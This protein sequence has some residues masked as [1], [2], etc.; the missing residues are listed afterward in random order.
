MNSLLAG[1]VALLALI[2]V[3]IRSRRQRSLPVDSG[4]VSQTWLLQ[5]RA[6]SKSD[7]RFPW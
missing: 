2:A 1:A 3:G 4:T 6:N 5:H 7:H